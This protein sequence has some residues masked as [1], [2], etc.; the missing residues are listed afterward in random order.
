MMCLRLN[1]CCF[2][3]APEQARKNLCEWHGTRD[4]IQKPLGHENEVQVA[5]GVTDMR[6][7]YELGQ[8]LVMANQ[9]IKEGR[10]TFRKFFHREFDRAKDCR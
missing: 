9:L 6:K 7:R 10:A 5:S 1:N 8:S 3:C 2:T 4:Y